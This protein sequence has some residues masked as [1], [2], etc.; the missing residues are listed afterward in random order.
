[1]VSEARPLAGEMDGAKAELLVRVN[2][3][4]ASETVVEDVEKLLASHP[5]E[6]PVVFEL[7][8]PGDFRARLR[9]R[10]GRGVKAESELLA[11]LR[12]I[13]GEDAVLLERQ[14]TGNRD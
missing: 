11:R 8:Q 5:G 10:R 7:I 4:Q 13:C 3:A 1:V 12:E 14:G 9:P 6:N 2:L